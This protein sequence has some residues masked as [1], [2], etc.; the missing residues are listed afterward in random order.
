MFQIVW[1][2]RNLTQSTHKG[3]AVQCRLSGVRVDSSIVLTGS[4]SWSKKAE[5]NNKENLIVMKGLYIAG[6]YEEEFEE[7]WEEKHLRSDIHGK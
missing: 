6:I 3:Q 7:I 2:D 4:F 1:H 5:E